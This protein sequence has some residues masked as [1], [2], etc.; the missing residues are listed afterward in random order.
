MR[1]HTYTRAP[2][3]NNYTPTE[4]TRALTPEEMVHQ[5]RTGATG[6]DKELEDVGM[7]AI[8]TAEPDSPM[9]GLNGGMNGKA[10]EM[11]SVKFLEKVDSTGYSSKVTEEEVPDAL[12]WVP[13]PGCESLGLGG[14]DSPT[15][16]GVK[17][18]LKAWALSAEN[19]IH[20]PPE[21]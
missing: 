3:T 17:T 13:E 2:P 10:A 1:T 14:C 9:E 18:H 4:V 6:E 19:Q 12:G 11:S 21:P 15:Q 5:T 20:P 8:E 16:G 7:H